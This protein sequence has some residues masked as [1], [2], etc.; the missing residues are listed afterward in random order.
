MCN[1]GFFLCIV[2]FDF[3]ILFVSSLNLFLLLEFVLFQSAYF[4]YLKGSAKK[5][6]SIAVIS[7]AVFICNLFQV[8]GGQALY[9]NDFIIITQQSLHIGAEKALLLFSL[10]LISSNSI[11]QNRDLLIAQDDSSLFSLSVRKFFYLF[12]GINF[13]SKKILKHIYFWFY[14]SLFHSPDKT[15]KVSLLS[16]KSFF[17]FHVAFF[18]LMIFSALLV[19]FIFK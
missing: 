8:T 11:Y 15:G 9:S 14:R 19:A 10:F 6:L 1:R 18:I 2:L 4:F 5:M 16:L 13:K 7:I 3:L 12:E 17:Y